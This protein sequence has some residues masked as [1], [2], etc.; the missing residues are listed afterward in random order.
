MGSLVVELD[1][2]ADVTNCCQL[3]V[4][5]R[6]MQ[7]IAVRTEPLPSHDLSNTTTGKDIFN[8]LD[9]FFQK[10]EL[11]WGKLFECTSGGVPSVLR[12]K[13]DFQAH[14][15]VVALNATTVHCFL[16]RFDL[17]AKVLHPK[18]LSCSH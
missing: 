5:V 4:Y 11:D 17:C 7:G 12:R 13:S 2:Y 6:F 9:N 18:F 15:K 8:V 16:H 1:E 3:L 10:N 14:L